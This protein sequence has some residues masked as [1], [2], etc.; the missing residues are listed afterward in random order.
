MKKQKTKQKIYKAAPIK[1]STVATGVTL[2]DSFYYLLTGMLTTTKD[3]FMAD[4][5]QDLIAQGVLFGYES[6]LYP[7]SRH[8]CKTSPKKAMAF[9]C[10]L[11]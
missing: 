5:D 7:M 8:A 9:P 3:Y 11:P 4:E 2:T 10:Y 1:S 6:R